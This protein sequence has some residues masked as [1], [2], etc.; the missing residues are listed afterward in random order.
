ML[1][2]VNRFVL[3]EDSSVAIIATPPRAVRLRNRGSVL[4]RGKRLPLKASRSAL[5]PT[6]APVQ[7][8]LGAH[9]RGGGGGAET[10]GA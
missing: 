8:V 9:S 4:I 1:A 3:F 6:Q 2:R 7:W 5:A 10:A